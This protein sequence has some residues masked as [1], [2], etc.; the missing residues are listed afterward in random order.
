MRAGIIVQP[1]W[2]E[3]RTAAAPH[4]ASNQLLVRLE[5][6]GVCGSN[7]PVW[8]GRP[9][10]AYP[11]APGAPGHEAWGVVNEIGTKVR[12]FRPGD[13]VALLAEFGFAEFLAVPADRAV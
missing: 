5:G 11:L 1:R 10:F 12:E 13:R 2:A 8:E 9:W 3:I 4:C 7:L 6:C